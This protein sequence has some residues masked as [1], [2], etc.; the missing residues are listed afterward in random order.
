MKITNVTL[1]PIHSRRETGLISPHVIVELETDEG[2]VGLGEMSDFGHQPPYLAPHLDGLC[3]ALKELL[4]GRDPFDFARIIG[5]LAQRHSGVVGSLIVCGIDLALHDLQGKALGRPVSDLLGGQVRDRLRVCYPIFPMRQPEDV[6]QNLKRVADRLAEGQDVFRLYIGVDL[7]LDEAFLDGFRQRFG[8]QVVLK[9]IDASGRFRDWR[10]AVQAIRRLRQYD[11]MLV[12]SP[13]WRG[14]LA[15]MA[16]VRRQVDIPISEHVGSLTDAL[17]LAQARAVDIFNISLCS[18]GGI[19]QARKVY[20][21]A[22]A[23]G[24][25]CLIG[26]TQELS[27]G[28]AGQAH[29]GAAMPN[30]HFPADPTGPLLFLDDV[31]RS[32]VRYE[33]G[34]LIVPGG[35][36][37]GMELDHEKLRE[38]RHELHT[39][40]LRADWRA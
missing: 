39:A 29:L 2:L 20:A 27:I 36:G 21:L 8:K 16:E 7:D 11:F 3:A 30:L 26:T 9:S 18:L 40:P 10:I 32:R 37:L 5:A 28:T 31:V 24:L 13:C 25:A 4:F 33:H 22:E 34:Y 38:F 15:G 17:Q 6:E 23:T 14:D 12:E 19:Y 1:T 35:P